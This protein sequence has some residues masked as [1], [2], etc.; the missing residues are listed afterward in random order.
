MASESEGESDTKYAECQT[1]G[2]GKKA[3]WKDLKHFSEVFERNFSTTKGTKRRFLWP[4]KILLLPIMHSQIQYGVWRDHQSGQKR[5]YKEWASWNWGTKIIAKIDKRKNDDKVDFG[6]AKRSKSTN[7]SMVALSSK[8]RFACSS[9]VCVPTCNIEWVLGSY[10]TRDE[11][12]VYI[13]Y[14]NY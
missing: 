3:R 11:G 14:T 12:R 10:T 7:I 6:E 1:P 13:S 4:G 8:D 2:C 9:S 5:E